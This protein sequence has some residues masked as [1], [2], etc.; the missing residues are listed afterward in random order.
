MIPS[1][2]SSIYHELSPEDA[3]RRIAG[4]GFPGI[5]LSTEHLIVLREDDRAAHR[6]PSFAQLVSELGLEMSQAHI[7]ISVDVAS[8]DEARRRADQA[9]VERDI[10]VLCALGIRNGVLHPGGHG[11]FPTWELAHEQNR[12]RI[13]ALGRLADLAEGS[14]VRLA[15]ENG[16]KTWGPLNQLA[17]EGTVASIRDLIAQIGSPALGI[18]LDTGHAVLE[19]W[20]NAEAVGTA[21]DRLIALHIA[22][23]DGSGDQHRIPYSFAS[24]IDWP[25]TVSAL[26][27]I[28][29]EGLFNLEIP[30][31]SRRPMAIRDAVVRYALEVSNRLLA[32]EVGPSPV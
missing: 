14:G 29:Y 7:T 21:G 32:G 13:E 20:D 5:E 23:N 4:M 16:V 12:V 1:M 6:V 15:L 22:D 8:A 27:E 10:Q 28:G 19:G 30:G 2:W 17:W 18:C 26:R 9:T 24:K 31:E 11:S 25:A 3:V